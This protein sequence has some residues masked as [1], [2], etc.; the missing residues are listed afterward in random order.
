MD[1]VD[2]GACLSQTHAVTNTVA[3]TDPARV[4]KP[5]FGLVLRTLLCEH[6]CVH[7][8]VKGQE[9]LTITG[10]EG[11]LRLGDTNLGSCNLRGVSRDEMV[12]GLLWVELG[13]G[14]HDSERV[15]GEENNVLRMATNSGNLHV[16]DMLKRIANTRVRC[17]ADIVVVDDALPALFLMVASVLDNGAKLDGVENIRLFGA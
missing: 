16:S 1:R 13:Y 7:I 4:D 17:Q 6:L 2:D 15:A 5:D 12:H 8:W 3:T 10:R 9:S 11:Q 14:R